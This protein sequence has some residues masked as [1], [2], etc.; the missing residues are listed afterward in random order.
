MSALR[1]AIEH[2]TLGWVKPELDTALHQIQGDIEAFVEAPDDV[3]PLRDATQQLRQIEGTLRMLE[4]YAPAT[5]IEEMQ[6]LT[7]A[8]SEGEISD[9]REEACAALGRAAIQLPDYLERLQSGHRDIPVV[10]L[11]LLNELRGFRGEASLGES[12]LFSPDFERPLPKEVA[13]VPVQAPTGGRELLD[14]YEGDLRRL[15]NE[16]QSN[17]DVSATLLK[18][19]IDGL[20]GFARDEDMRRLLWVASETAQAVG[21]GALTATRQL[22]EAFNSVVEEV[23][24]SRQETGLASGNASSSYLPVRKLLQQVARIDTPNPSLDRLRDTFGLHQQAVSA[25]ELAHAQSSVTGVN[26]AL[27][28]TVT[29]A[30]KED[31]FRVK[32]SLD[33][34]LRTGNTN[35]DDLRNEVDALSR[36]SD[37]LGMLGLGGARDLI[38][39]QRDLLAGVVDGN[40]A[41][42]E[43]VLLDVAGALLFV[44]ASLE[45]QVAQLG[46]EVGRGNGEE[47]IRTSDAEQLLSALTREAVVNFGDARQA[48]V[49]FVETGWDH[50]ALAEVPRLLNEVSGALGMLELPQCADYVSG[51]RLFT[52]NELIQKRRVPGSQQLDTFADAIASVEYYLEALRDKRA[53]REDILAITQQS[54]EALR[55]WPLPSQTTEAPMPSLGNDIED[56]YEAFLETAT[57]EQKAADDH[58]LAVT[59]QEELEASDAAQIRPWARTDAT[60]AQKANLAVRPELQFDLTKDDIDDEIREIFVEEFKD[61]I[62]NLGILLPPWR[63]APGDAERLRPIRRVFHTLKGSGRLVGATKLG[64]FSWKVENMLNRV[65]DGSRPASPEVVA[66]VGAAVDE[67]P[68]L[69]GALRNEAVAEVDFDGIETAADQLANGEEV[70]YVRAVAAPPEVA[71]P[72]HMPVQIDPV[73]FEILSA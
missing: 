56:A 52:E 70:T 15:L 5:L 3:G 72:T 23:Q 13:D 17:G 71:A 59:L 64:E 9:V 16:W 22:R 20:F 60:D 58:D 30:L 25:E 67:L 42:D 51:I 8:L 68:S 6:A 37:T 34:H 65:L 26:R 55:Y 27:L 61:E 21:D 29:G 40:K 7:H 47:S 18:E 41:A 54:L 32:D 49:A 28:D 38:Q 63:Q 43:S 24:A 57:A 11:P 46:R 45:D 19:R 12:V 33:L 66:L 62:E 4:L 2:A 31:V 44:D 48:F 50:A 39:R 73:V 35:P 10:L 14:Q 53:D 1:E 69:Y 36:I